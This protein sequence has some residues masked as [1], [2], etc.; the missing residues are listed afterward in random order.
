MLYTMLYLLS[1][2]LKMFVVLT[3][4]IIKYHKENISFLLFFSI[5]ADNVSKHCKKNQNYITFL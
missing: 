2:I 1:Q 5:A 3:S 4:L